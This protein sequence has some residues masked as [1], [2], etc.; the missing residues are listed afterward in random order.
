ML[1]ACSVTLRTGFKFA[2]MEM[3]KAQPALRFDPQRRAA[4]G[5]LRANIFELIGHLE[6]EERRL[7]LRSRE[8]RDKDRKNFQMAVESL[9]CNLLVTAITSAK[10]TLSVPRGHGAMWGNGRYHDP[11]YGQHFL[12]LIDMLCELGFADKVTHGY[13][14]SKNARQSTTIRPT[15]AFNKRMQSGC[16]KWDF[17][18]QE[19]APELLILK[20]TKDSNGLAEPI[21]YKDTK[22]TS[23]WRR[24][25]AKLNSWLRDAPISLLEQ[26][27]APLHLDR[28]GQPIETHRRGLRR[29]FNNADWQQ[30]GRLFGGFWENMER[31]ARFRLLRIMGEPVVNVDF[32][33]LFPRLA[34]VR[35]REEQPEGDLYDITGNGSCRDGWKQLINALLFAERP[36][37]G[38]PRDIREK[39]PLGLSLRGAIEE[40]K[41]KHAPIA[42][43]FEQG[44]GFRLMRIESD[45][46]IVAVT[47]LFKQGITALPLHDS[48]LTA[49]SHGDAAKAVLENIFRQHTGS[50]RATVKIDCGPI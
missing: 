40:I 5:A 22:R 11:I 20:P 50:A 43:L 6:T 44:L 3:S 30:G 4:N 33:S 47:A 38:W 12:S 10:A 48:V 27:Q 32:G 7:S 31:S 24:E 2:A 46:L 34:Y 21:N 28:D 37:R 1:A 26:D 42:H 35:A 18:R 29:I 8:R 39:L 41:A 14:F 17:F 25:I 19:D 36:L 13:R 23:Q 16:L 49:R 15:K 9:A 45:M